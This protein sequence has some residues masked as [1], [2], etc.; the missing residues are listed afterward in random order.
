MASSTRRFNDSLARDLNINQDIPDEGL[1]SI[2]NKMTQ[3]IRPSKSS[4]E[5]THI[6]YI[7]SF[8]QG[9]PSACLDFVT[10]IWI[11]FWI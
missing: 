10:A 9:N 11:L 1:N 5:G 6:Q 4:F 7:Q 8:I 3:T 2:G